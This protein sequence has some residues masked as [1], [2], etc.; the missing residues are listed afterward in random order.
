MVH[1]DVAPYFAAAAPSLLAPLARPAPPPPLALAAPL[2]QHLTRRLLA[3][4][5]TP[6]SRRLIPGDAPYIR[7]LLVLKTGEL[8]VERRRGPVVPNLPLARWCSRLHLD[9]ARLG[10]AP[11]RSSR[12][13]AFSL[14]S[15]LLLLAHLG[16]APSRSS[17][18]CASSL[19]SALRLLAHLGPALR[20]C[21]FQVPPAASRPS[22]T[23]RRKN[24]EADIARTFRCASS[25]A[26]PA[27]ET[28]HLVHESFLLL[29]SSPALRI[30]LEGGLIIEK[31]FRRIIF[32]DKP[33][34][35]PRRG[36]NISDFLYFLRT[37]PITCRS[38]PV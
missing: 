19:I 17:R 38:H 7:T 33:T 18:P 5:P 37:A 31:Q 28:A 1:G 26:H 4:R 3:T 6:R 11:P 24:V 36:A 20:P 2:V 8:L 9:L 25:I 32:L 23:Y 10:P 29:S 34:R 13:C 30:T 16:P 14:I 35:L 22:S 27:H 21:L 12:P 15:A